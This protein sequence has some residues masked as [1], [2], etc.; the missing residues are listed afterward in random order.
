M[1]QQ[2]P[3]CLA[4]GAAGKSVPVCRRTGTRILTRRTGRTARKCVSRDV[5]QPR[6]SFFLGPSLQNVG[7]VIYR[8]EDDDNT[9]A[10]FH[11]MIG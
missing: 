4:G 6:Q 9:Y 5:S 7:P 8:D 1:S 10:K 3:F 2:S 11:D